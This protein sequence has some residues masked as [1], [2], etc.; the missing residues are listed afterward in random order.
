MGRHSETGSENKPRRAVTRT[1]TRQKSQVETSA[2]TDQTGA[3]TNRKLGLDADMR[4]HMIAES[5]YF[6][7]EKRG[8]LTGYEIQDWLEAEAEID[9]TFPSSAMH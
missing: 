7:A 2:R 8:F 4:R 9:L 3:K 6:R 5:A 1:R